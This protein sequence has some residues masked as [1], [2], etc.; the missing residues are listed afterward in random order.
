[1]PI[2]LRLTNNLSFN[3]PKHVIMNLPVS[4]QKTIYK[5]YDQLKKIVDHYGLDSEIAL[6]YLHYEII[7]NRGGN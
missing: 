1:M 6:A 7:I 5:V 4:R 3:G 2:D